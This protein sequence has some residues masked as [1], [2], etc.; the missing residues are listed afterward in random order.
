M[1]DKY[2]LEII[3]QTLIS[4]NFVIMKRISVLLFLVTIGGIYNVNAQEEVKSE[5]PYKFKRAK[6]NWYLSWGYNLDWYSKSDIHFSDSRRNGYYDFVIEDAKAEDRPGLKNLLTTD[7]AIPQYAFRIGF[8]GGANRDWG[9]EFNYDHA[10]YVVTPGQTVHV[11]GKYF[12]QQLDNNVVIQYN[13]ISSIIVAIVIM[14][15]DFSFN[16]IMGLFYKMFV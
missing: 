7:L 6:Y 1:K 16:G 5:S 15:M 13:T 14:T 2:Q 11:K 8:F 12:G 4:A 9:F 10:K 3:F